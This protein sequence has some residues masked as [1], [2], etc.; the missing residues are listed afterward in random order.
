MSTVELRFYAELNDF[1]RDARKQTRFKHVLNRRT[2]VKDLIESLGV[3]HTEV[4]VILANGKSVDFSYIVKDKDDLSIYPM[5]ESVDVT[6]ILKLRDAPLR[7]TRFVLD[8]HLGRLA[9]YLR[10]LGFDTLYRND[11]ADDELADTSAREH[12]ILLTRDRSLLKRSIITHGYFVREFDP[13]KQLDEVIRRFDLRNQIIPFGRCTRCNGMVEAVSK[14][15]V[16]HLLEPKT[17]Q[18]F[19][20]FWQC[21]SCGQVYWEGSHVKHML[22]LTDD[23]LNPDSG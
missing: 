2:S 19:D 9:R 13:R 16:E 12:R 21:T 8:C 15:T 14:N 4:E 6:P 10:Q 5:F 1:L 23:V 3:P 7:H 18:Y 22:K 11:Y 20:E 17:R